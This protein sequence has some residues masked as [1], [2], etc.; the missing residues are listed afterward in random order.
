M[1]GQGLPITA[2]I[3]I[4]IAIV[5]LILV[6][7]FII[8][9]ILRFNPPAP[10]NSSLQTFIHN[11]GDY[12]YE[13]SVNPSRYVNLFCTSTL[14]SGSNTYYCY[15]SNVYG[16]CSYKAPNGTRETVTQASCG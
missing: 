9:P 15:N 6:I 16:S 4:V 13:A 10:Q 14:T 2:V 5:I 7:V 8:L 11:C 12:C 1:K 3:L